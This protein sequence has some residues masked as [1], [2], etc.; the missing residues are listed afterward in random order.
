[1]LGVVTSDR[2]EAVDASKGG[3]GG[4]TV[5]DG[6]EGPHIVDVEVLGGAELF[7]ILELKE[8]VL[9]RVD[10]ATIVHLREHI[11]NPVDVCLVPAW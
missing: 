11:I 3:A 2:L 1:M 10:I 5:L 8:Q 4:T 7:V 6:K 9:R